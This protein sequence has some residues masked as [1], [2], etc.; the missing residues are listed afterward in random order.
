[1]CILL[2]LIGVQ[3]VDRKEFIKWMKEDIYENYVK[4]QRIYDA[5]VEDPDGET[6]KNNP[7][8]KE[9]YLRT[10]GYGK[11]KKTKKDYNVHR[12]DT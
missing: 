2:A 6:A 7:Y 1:M 12:S 9:Y 10:R 8:I 5:I 3:I 4:C 11:N